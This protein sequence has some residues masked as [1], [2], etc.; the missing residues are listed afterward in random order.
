MTAGDLSFWIRHSEIQKSDNVKLVWKLDIYKGWIKCYFVYISAS[1]DLYK[2]GVYPYE[3]GGE[4][5]EFFITIYFKEK[6]NLQIY[7]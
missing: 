2:F 1:M 4:T 5:H 6:D 3:Y 7:A